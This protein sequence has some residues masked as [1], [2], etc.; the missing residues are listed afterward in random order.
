MAENEENEN[1]D[2]LTTE[3]V[4]AMITAALAAKG[5]P[6]LPPKLQALLDEAEAE[7]LKADEEKTAPTP[8]PEPDPEPPKSEEPEVAQLVV[9]Y[10]ELIEKIPADKR[11][12]LKEA[13]NGEKFV[14]KVKFLEKLTSIGAYAPEAKGHI[15][16]R[17]SEN[18]KF[19]VTS[20]ARENNLY[21]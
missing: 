17:E 1:Q 7:K 16:G 2:T 21:K 4:Q 9:Q 13:L 18:Q 8:D 14:D 3:K 15:K 10:M 12:K 5:E 11:D 19:D 6:E 20:W